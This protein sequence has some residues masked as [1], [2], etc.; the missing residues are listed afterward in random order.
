METAAGHELDMEMLKRDQQRIENLQLFNR[1]EI[2][3]IEQ[4]DGVTV[5]VMVTERWFIFPYPIL[6]ANERDWKKLSYGAGIVHRNFRGRNTNIGLSGWLGYNSGFSLYYANPRVWGDTHLYLTLKAFAGTVRSRGLE[7]ERFDMTSRGGLIDIGKRWGLC[8]YTSVIVSYQSIGFPLQYEYLS[9]G[10]DHTDRL[11]SLVLVFKYDHRDLVEYPKSG[12]FFQTYIEKVHYPSQ[13]DYLRSGIDVRCYIPLPAGIS[14]A[15]RSAGDLLQGDNPM[16]AR[17]YL[18]YSER[19]RGHY[20]EVRQGDYRLLS[21]LELRF[22]IV[23]LQHFS[24][25]ESMFGPSSSNMPFAL[26]GAIFAETGTTWSRGEQIDKE[27]FLSGYGAGIHVQLPY[28]YL[29]RFD[30]GLNLDG[31]GEFI[32]D[33]NAWF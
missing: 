2:E 16:Y 23:S 8:T 19:I 1:V 15:M 20:A 3:A 25:D 32:F 29:L 7:V 22:P 10:G 13:V 30:Y 27:R 28:S 9:A 4:P 18:G 12:L 31:D 21:Q 11:P 5:L 6:Y 26:H 14:L 17:H 33:L 24:V